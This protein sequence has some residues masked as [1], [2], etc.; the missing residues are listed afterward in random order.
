MCRVHGNGLLSSVLLCGP[1]SYNTR[2]GG[3]RGTRAAAARRTEVANCEAF[4]EADE[5]HADEYEDAMAKLDITESSF[6]AIVTRGHKD[7]M[8]V[9]RWA[10]ATPARYIGMIGSKRKAIEVFKE[11]EAEGISRQRLEQVHTPI[12]LE[13]G[14]IT[15]EEIA[16]SAVAEL[17][18]V[19]RGGQLGQLTTKSVFAR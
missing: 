4:P 11:L 3:S 12:G 2:D 1:K 18:A 15:P 7:D 9:L 13:I 10:V 17:I 6:L 16:V 14:A 19:R 5:I 8:R